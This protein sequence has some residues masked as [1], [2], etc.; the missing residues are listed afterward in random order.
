MVTRTGN[1]RLYIDL[2]V[3]E[4]LRKGPEGGLQAGELRCAVGGRT[5]EITPM[6][7]IEDDVE[8]P[9]AALVGDHVLTIM[10]EGK[11]TFSSKASASASSRALPPF[12]RPGGCIGKVVQV[13]GPVVVHTIPVNKAPDHVLKFLL[14]V[15]AVDAGAAEKLG[16]L[17]TG[18]REGGTA[19]GSAPPR[20]CPTG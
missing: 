2:R 15:L 9:R 17:V 16:G 13:Q 18:Q 3:E 7:T 19:H 10:Q 14:L 1:T 11:T 4:G 5:V 12:I 8:V 20:L 6:G